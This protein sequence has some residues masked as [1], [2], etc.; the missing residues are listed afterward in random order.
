MVSAETLGEFRYWYIL[1][2]RSPKLE[3]GKEPW[4]HKYSKCALFVFMIAV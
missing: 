4:M 1:I 2:C 3:M